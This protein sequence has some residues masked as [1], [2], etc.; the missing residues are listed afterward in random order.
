MTKEELDTIERSGIW[1]IEALFEYFNRAIEMQ[2]QKYEQHFSHQREAVNAA[3]QSAEKAILKAEQAS[4]KRFDAVNEFRSVLAD[5][6]RLLMTRSEYEV[7]HRNIVE[8]T[9]ALEKRIEKRENMS[10]GASHVAAY[11][12]GGFGLLLTIVSIINMIISFGKP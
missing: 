7:N 2:D 8:A 11:V 9:L 1:T 6:Q 12:V 10:S 5:Q 3:L 4:E